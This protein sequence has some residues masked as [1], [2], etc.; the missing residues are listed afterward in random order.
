MIA[1]L[2]ISAELLNVETAEDI[3]DVNP[4]LIASLLTSADPDKD[5]MSDVNPDLIA[6]LFTSAEEDKVLTAEETC[7]SVAKVL[8]NEAVNASKLPNLLSCVLLVDPNELISPCKADLIASLLTSA[9]LL[10]P[11]TAELMSDASPLLIAS[12]FTSAE[13]DKDV[14]DE[15]LVEISDAKAALIASLFTSAEPDKDVTLPSILVWRALDEVTYPAKAESFSVSTLLIK[16]T[17]SAKVSVS[18]TEAD[19][20]AS[21]LPFS[22][23]ILLS[24]PDSIAF[25]WLCADPDKDD[26][27]DVNPDLI[28]SLFTSAEED[29]LLTAELMSDVNPDLIASLL[30]SAELLNVLTADVTSESVA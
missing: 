11:D 8:S 18:A 26:M 19:K 25:L 24:N 2:L 20:I 29:K 9:E 17:I 1:S 13:E 23:P 30:T 5:D 14:I 3:S 27:S 4:D 10:K 22:V 16:V 6:S 7:A 12:L 15:L 21:I 28:A